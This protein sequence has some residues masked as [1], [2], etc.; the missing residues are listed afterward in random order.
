MRKV[1][2]QGHHGGRMDGKEEGRSVPGK[3]SRFSVLVRPR[4]AGHLSTP[5]SEAGSH[6]E[7]SRGCPC[8]QVTLDGRGRWGGRR[9][10][11][12]SRALGQSAWQPWLP[13]RPSGKT[14][15]PETRMTRARHSDRCDRSL[16]CTLTCRG[17]QASQGLEAVRV[18]ARRAGWLQMHELPVC[19]YAR[20]LLSLSVPSCPCGHPGPIATCP[21]TP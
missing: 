14:S 7:S 1:S 2:A 6:A 9:R 16:T 5:G 21:A 3:V 10:R 4:E 19:P 8:A 12:H 11:S 15:F 17:A 18:T 13:S 20:P